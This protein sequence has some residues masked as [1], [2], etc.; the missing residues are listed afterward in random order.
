MALQ[1]ALG[2]AAYAGEYSGA[3]VHR[4]DSGLYRPQRSAIRQ[5]IMDR[6]GSVPTGNGRPLLKSA[7]GY[8]AKI[9]PLPRPV[10]ND[11][12]EELAFFWIALQG[13]TPSLCVALG[14]MQ[15]TPI[16]GLEDY[17]GELEVAV[18]C[19]SKNLRS[20]VDGR[21]AP[22]SVATGD[23][24]ADP[25]VETML[26]HV[27]EILAGQDIGLIGTHDMDPK[28][29]NEVVTDGE[30]TIWEL[31]FSLVVDVIVNPERVNSEVATSL[32]VQSNLDGL[33]DS[34]QPIVDSIVPIEVP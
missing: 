6:L 3:A 26:E 15:I 34:Q 21:M 30:G 22:D 24:T 8:I 2:G 32:E 31:K 17:L 18:Y 14:G 20:F 27:R 16:D 23:P 33:S 25:G 7:G 4:F 1:G 13:T 11:S 12:D 29:E 9:A 19:L 5:A 10:K 28:S